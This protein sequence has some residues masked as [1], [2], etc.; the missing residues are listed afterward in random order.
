MSNE[1]KN[2]VCIAETHTANISALML[3]KSADH[4]LLNNYVSSSLN[5]LSQECLYTLALHAA[6][7]DNSGLFV[8]VVNELHDK[9]HVCMDRLY[10]KLMCM[11]AYGY[12][13]KAYVTTSHMLSPDI[14]ISALTY[15]KCITSEV[16]DKLMDISDTYSDMQYGNLLNILFHK[17]NIE[18]MDLIIKM[19]TTSEVNDDVYIFVEDIVKNAVCSTANQILIKNK[20]I[21]M[22]ENK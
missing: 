21:Q 15:D 10:K 19:I 17:A 16:F 9:H 2:K 4:S 5:F 8:V 22:L 12:L 18:S 13:T 3:Y 1:N 11:H 14:L 7:V 6:S 20:L